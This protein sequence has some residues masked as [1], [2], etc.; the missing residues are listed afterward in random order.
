MKPIKNKKEA[1]RR[2]KKDSMK[3]FCFLLLFCAAAAASSERQGQDT[4]LKTQYAEVNRCLL[5]YIESGHSALLEGAPASAPLRTGLLDSLSKH[6][7]RR[8]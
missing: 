3:L 1:R 6:K 4:K 5:E 7:V 2:A 8:R